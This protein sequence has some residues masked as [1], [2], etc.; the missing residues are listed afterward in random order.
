MKKI[1]LILLAVVTGMALTSSSVV[2]AAKKKGSAKKMTNAEFAV[3]IAEVTGISSPNPSAN[4]AIAACNLNGISINPQDA[5]KP[6]TVKEVLEVI[7]I[8]A[9]ATPED[10]KSQ[11]TVKAFFKANGIAFTEDIRDLVESQFPEAEADVFGHYDRLGSDLEKNKEP[12]TLPGIG[13]F[14]FYDIP[15][16]AIFAETVLNNLLNS[17][18]DVTVTLLEAPTT[19]NA[20]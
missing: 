4:E 9:G 2:F 16:N 3:K 6:V 20:N 13:I 17:A 11:A 7:A 14:D 10:C 15:I 1:G 12:S 19:P 5:D 8:L 18:G